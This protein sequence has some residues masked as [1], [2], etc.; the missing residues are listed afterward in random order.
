MDAQHASRGRRMLEEIRQKRVAERI[1]KASSGSDLEASNIYGMPIYDGGSRSSEKD[2]NALLLRLKE[3]EKKNTELEIEKI[4]VQSKLEVSQAEK[5]TLLRR[6]N[7]LEQ[8][9]LPSLRKSLQ[10]LSIEKDAA[11][12]AR[13]DLLAQVRA[14]KKRL[15][16][17]EEEQYRAEEDAAALRA[18]LNAMQQNEMKNQFNDIA[19]MDRS[20]D[21]IKS[22]ETENLE[23][24]SQLQNELVKNQE[25]LQR[26]AEE[27]AKSSHLQAQMQELEQQLSALS[28]TS[29]E[30]S[31]DVVSKTA[32]AKEKEK[33]EKQLHDLAVMVERLENGR[34]KLL[35]EVDSQ[36]SQIEKLYEENADLSASYNDALKAIAEWESQVKSCL[37][38]NK[39]LRETLHKLRTDKRLSLDSQGAEALQQLKGELADEESRSEALSAE[40]LRLSSEL[41]LASQSYQKLT[42]MYRPVLRNIEESLM[43][44]KQ[45]SFVSV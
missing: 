17:A 30:L 19:S 6:V 28:K 25:G 13:E 40:V 45:E 29:E 38:Q 21:L 37:E 20:T 39:E 33:L 23:L 22:M 24:K 27:Q 10:D 35:L 3:L 2:F 26:L 8:E 11:V 44:M 36:S 41:K 43:K 7:V 34:Q 42:W 16:V 1:Q 4:Q 31:R 15:Q 5:E 12:V 9:T 32:L 14:L 18:E